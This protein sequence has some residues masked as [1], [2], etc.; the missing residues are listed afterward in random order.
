MVT[1]LCVWEAEVSIM[2]RDFHIAT[3]LVSQACAAFGLVTTDSDEGPFQTQQGISSS[4]PRLQGSY[5]QG[6][7]E[8]RTFIRRTLHL[9][10]SLVL[11]LAWKDP[12]AVC[13]VYPDQ[14]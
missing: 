13:R 11:L 8:R 3:P 1:M 9:P 6:A 10:F 12:Y 5:S 4:A 7:C 2:Q 14:A